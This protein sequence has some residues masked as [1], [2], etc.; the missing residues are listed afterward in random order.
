V[1]NTNGNLV[2]TVAVTLKGPMAGAKKLHQRTLDVLNWDTGWQ[3]P[4]NWTVP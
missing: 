2:M 3:Q 1:A 4:G